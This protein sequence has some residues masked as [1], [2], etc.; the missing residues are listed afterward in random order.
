MIRIVYSGRS[1]YLNQFFI[2]VCYWELPSK[3]AVLTKNEDIFNFCL[4]DATMWVK[5]STTV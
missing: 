3:E 4:Y 5:F 1:Y 2:S